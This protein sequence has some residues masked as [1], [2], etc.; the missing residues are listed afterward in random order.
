MSGS[1]GFSRSTI[2]QIATSVP[3]NL[4]KG[5]GQLLW[6]FIAFDEV[7]TTGFVI[8]NSQSGCSGNTQLRS[9]TIIR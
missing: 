7:I 4:L 2:K 6:R 9:L 3:K 1:Q 8:K 5:L